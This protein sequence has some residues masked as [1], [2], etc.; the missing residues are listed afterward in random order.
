MEWHNAFRQQMEKLLGE[1][2]PAFFAALEKEPEKALRL[3]P[4]RGDRQAVQAALA[5]LLGA[6]IPFAGDAW[7]VTGEHP[8]RHPLHAGGAF[9]LQDPAAMAP[10]SAVSVRPDDAILDLCAAP[11]GKSVAVGARLGRE[12]VLVC[13]EPSPARRRVLMQNL[14][15]CGIRAAVYGRN[16]ADPL[17]ETWRGAFD[18]VV[19]DVP[20]SGE[21]M[22]R[23]EPE[24]A[25]LW[26]PEKRDA[27]AAL[28]E[29]ILE[30]AGVA[31]APGGTLLY[32][33]C[34]W[35]TKENEEQIARF[36]T[37]RRDFSSAKVPPAVAA[38]SLPGVDLPGFDGANC[39]RFYPQVFPGEGQ[40]LAV[41][42]RKGE[43]PPRGIGERETKPRPG[44][45]VV[46]AFLEENLTQT[47]PG[48]LLERDGLWYLAGAFADGVSPGLLLGEVRK[49]RFLPHHRLFMAREAAFIRELELD[50]ASARLYLSG[51]ELPCDLPDGWGRATFLSCPLGGVKITG[52]RAKNHYPKGLR[53]CMTN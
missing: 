52:G 24:A 35:N 32:A 30:N 43:R 11:G 13:N 36:L 46:R 39:R 17:P 1:D 37:A 19:C 49:G 42:R 16:A 15:R 45:A 18:L 23:K 6:A 34:T 25:R 5:P 47:P 21:G 2:A 12:G 9:Y 44:E 48:A 22:F 14:E 51:A 4:G 26:S 41:L 20:C 8:G 3:L 50:E 7:L 33:T 27:C 40:F 28:Q 38:A 29:R 10:A 53:L 31:V